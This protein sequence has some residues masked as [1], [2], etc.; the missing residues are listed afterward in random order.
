MQNTFE[1]LWFTIYFLFPLHQTLHQSLKLKIINVLGS[2][3]LTVFAPVDEAFRVRLGSGNFNNSEG[4]SGSII[5]GLLRDDPN[6]RLKKRSWRKIADRFVLSHVVLAGP[7]DPP[8]YTAGLRFYQVRD[9]AYRFPEGGEITGEETSGSVD[10]G[11]DGITE[12]DNS[13]IGDDGQLPIPHSRDGEKPRYYQ[14]TIYKDSGE[15]NA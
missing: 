4:S 15:S 6:R 5:D 9:T 1:S 7:G 11:N 8:M 13:S 14:L 10:D 3:T 12:D 2:R